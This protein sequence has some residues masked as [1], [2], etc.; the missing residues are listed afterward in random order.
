MFVSAIR[1]RFA[2]S[3]PAHPSRRQRPPI[4]ST[5]P[6]WPET[7]RL[8]IVVTGASSGIG[9]ELARA[10]AHDQQ[11]LLLTGRDAAA[12]AALAQEVGAAGGEAH[13]LALDLSR[14]D[15]VA[16]IGA[17]L[18]DLGWTCDVLVNN[19]GFGRVGAAADLG[20]EDQ[21]RILDVNLR[22]AVALALAALPGMRTR[23]RGGILNVGSIAGFFPGPGM[24]LYYASKAGLGSFSEALWAEARLYGV[25]VTLLC[26]GPVRTPFLER[27][28]ARN[29][30]IFKCRRKPRQRAS[31]A[32]A[33]P[34]SG[35]GGVWSSQTPRAGSSPAPR[36]FSRAA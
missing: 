26:P 22:A 15:A 8:A 24:A 18:G 1:Q 36:R 33:G 32:A 14:P 5:T 11:P 2:A 30:R 16:A 27:S 23:R 29:A 19:A 9:T 28:G 31:A 13:A 7:G 4:P 20:A 17:A 12:L 3:L 21:L 35:A 10:A 34:G 25:T 6:P